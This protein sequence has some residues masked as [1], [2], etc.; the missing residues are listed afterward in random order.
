MC[1]T[2]STRTP[3][4][5]RLASLLGAIFTIVAIAEGR[6]NADDRA[7]PGPGKIPPP[8]PSPRQKLVVFTEHR[9][10][11]NHLE[12][13]ITTL[14][15]RKEAVVM[16]HGGIGREERVIAQES[17]KHDPDVRVLLATDAAGEGINLQRAHLMVNYDLPWN[18]NRL[19][20]AFRSHPSY[21]PDRGLPPVESGRRRNARRRRVSQAAGEE[22]E[23]ARRRRRLR[24]RHAQQLQF[25]GVAQLRDLLIEAI[26]YGDK[27]DVRARLT[28][29]LEHALNR[30]QLRD[31]LEERAFA[32]DAMDAS[33]VFRIREEM[34]RA[35]ARRLQPHY[36]ESFFHDAFRRLGGSAKQRETRCWSLADFR[37][38]VRNR[39]RLIGIGEPGAAVE[40]ITF[41]KSLVPA[42]TALAAGRLRRPGH[43][44]LADSVIDLTLD[45]HRDLLK[46]DARAG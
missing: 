37:R 25:E 39:D 34:E 45:R 41:E 19:R 3:N 20:A 17:F 22:L 31:L 4:P 12:T 28:T 6:G 7:R 38:P 27:A 1:D 21:R 40:R 11:L 36:I 9:D 2:A 35:E 10:T 23:E 24:L 16:I 29:E 33:R 46:R 15:G 5:A 14:L 26:R 44:P 30:D 8:K 18:P 32:H 13:R 43:Q 42:R